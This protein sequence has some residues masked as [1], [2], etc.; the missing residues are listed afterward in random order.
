MPL[1]CKQARH[2]PTAEAEAQAVGHGML[3]TLALALGP[4]HPRVSQ[5]VRLLEPAASSLPLSGGT[6]LAGAPSLRQCPPE[7]AGATAAREPPAPPD[8]TWARH[9]IETARQAMAAGGM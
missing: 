6:F 1:E 3:L 2:R 7:G 4:D 9:A 5:V 8:G